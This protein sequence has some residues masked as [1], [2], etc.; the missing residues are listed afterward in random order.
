M[1]LFLV[2]L[3]PEHLNLYGDRGNILALYQRAQWHG[4]ELEVNGVGLDTGFDVNQADILFMGG[5]QDA[6]QLKVTHDLKHKADLIKQAVNEHAVMLGICGGYQLMGHYYQPHQG[7]RLEG[8]SLIDAHTVAGNKRMIGNVAIMR[9]NGQTVVGF[10]NHSGKTYLGQGLS[11]L[12]KVI[13]GYGNNGEDQ[14]EGVCQ[15]NLYGTY[16]HGSLLPKNPQLTDELLLKA[17]QKRYGLE[18]KLNNMVYS[19]IENVAHQRALA[20]CKG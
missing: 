13:G 10:E 20:L 19:E 1:K 16:L 18:A 7:D 11:P 5:G 4:L 14:L 9:P 8:L 12:G 2:H 17:L 3:Y 6:Q 15:G